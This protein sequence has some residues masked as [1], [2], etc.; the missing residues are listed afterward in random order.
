MESFGIFHSHLVFFKPFRYI[1]RQYCIVVAI[2]V[3]FN[4][5][6]YIFGHFG[7]L[8]LVFHEKSANPRH[9]HKLLDLHLNLTFNNERIKSVSAVFNRNYIFQYFPWNRTKG[10]SREKYWIVTVPKQVFSN[11]L[12]QGCQIFMTHYTKTGKNV[13]N[14]HKMYQLVSKYTNCP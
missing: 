3:Y 5:V 8:F 12:C 11:A 6:W 14:V 10:L 1:S 7:K 2:L 13:P 9:T 4:A